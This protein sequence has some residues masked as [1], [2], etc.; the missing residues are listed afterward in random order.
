[1]ES[2]WEERMEDTLGAL[3]GFDGMRELLEYCQEP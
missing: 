2:G 3:L 1:M